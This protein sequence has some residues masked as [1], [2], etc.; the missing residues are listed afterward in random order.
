M[1]T[2]NPTRIT[3]KRGETSLVDAL[4]YPATYI[5]HAP[6][7]L[8]LLLGSAADKQEIRRLALQVAG[9]IGL[10]LDTAG[11]GDLLVVGIGHEQ[12]EWGADR[13]VTEINRK[14]A[15]ACPHGCSPWCPACGEVR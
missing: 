10:S 2:T 11:H 9:E 13:L 4:R 7:V 14:L 6:T 1:A 12:A 5:E 8:L 15:G 3:F